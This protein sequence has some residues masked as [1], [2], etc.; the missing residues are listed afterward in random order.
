MPRSQFA[1]T[2]MVYLAGDNSLTSECLFALTE[3]K[4]AKL[5]DDICVVAQFDPRDNR[6]LTQRYQINRKGPHSTLFEDLFDEAKF[7]PKTGEVHFKKESVNARALAKRRQKARNCRCQELDEANLEDSSAQDQVITDDTD[8]G[9]PITL[10]NFISLCLEKYPA[11]HYMVVLSGHAGGTQRDYLLKDESSSGSLTFNELKQVFKRI[12]ADRKGELIDIVGMDNCQMSMVEVCYELR[13]LAQL[14]VGCESYSP[15]SGWPYRQILDRLQT[16]IAHSKKGSL[17]ADVAKGMVEE[18][19]NYYSPYW[20]SGMSV[21]QSA[22]DLN[23]VVELRRLID[24]FARAM[25]GELIKEHKQRKSAGGKV[26]FKDALV[27]AHWS[28]QSYN[29]ELYADLYDF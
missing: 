17:V 24:K 14:V 8:T 1:W 11:D 12:K 29:G 13:G 26:S 15:A 10:Y 7:D 9:S 19:V 16:T 4:K 22:M 23:K 27:L 28:T 6:L 2:V 18:Y 21:S 25:E 3:M 5:G 20:L